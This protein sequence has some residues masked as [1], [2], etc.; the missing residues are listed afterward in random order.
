[1]AGRWKRIGRLLEKGKEGEGKE[2]EDLEV[3]EGR[4][5]E[6]LEALSQA[7]VKLAQAS[8]RLFFLQ[9][10]LAL[11]EENSDASTRSCSICYEENLE[12]EQ[13][14]ITPCA[15]RL[16]HGSLCC[17]ELLFFCSFFFFF[18]FLASWLSGFLVVLW[19]KY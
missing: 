14:G 1:M 5:Q 17:Q 7:M 13:L 4:G 8:G 19:L 12:L 3:L 2:G 6:G 10:T 15:A 11:V 9:R 18:G 16:G